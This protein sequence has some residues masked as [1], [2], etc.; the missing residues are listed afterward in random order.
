M[1]LDP[2]YALPKALAAWCYAQRLSYLRTRNPAEDRSRA[3]TLA[4]DAVRLD[5]NDPLVLTCAGAAYSITRDYALAQSLIEKAL[6][7]DPNSAW[8]CQRSG[9]INVYLRQSDTALEQFKRAMR[10]SPVDPLMFN[11]FIG[12]GCAYI[13]K[14]EYGEAAHWIDK[15][16]REKPDA[17][18]AYRPLTAALFHAGRI[19]EA[20][21]TCTT[22]LRHFPNLTVSGLI[23]STPGN[24]FMR[25]KYAE[26]FRALGLPSG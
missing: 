13:D 12:I 5:N 17:V 11:I 19:E 14:A 18:W 3:T 10:L 6:K 9:W 21:L 22:L 23:E 24:D 4:Q 2:T 20:K 15:G 1:A 26:A 25:G 8:T 7:L 16:L